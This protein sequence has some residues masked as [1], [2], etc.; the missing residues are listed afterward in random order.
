MGWRVMADGRP[1]HRSKETKVRPYHKPEPGAAPLAPYA[2]AVCR[3]PWYWVGYDV[4]KYR[5]HYPG[6]FWERD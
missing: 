3:Q 5:R 4:F 1:Y 2:C 6:T